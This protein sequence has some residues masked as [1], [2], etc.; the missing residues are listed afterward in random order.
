M[1][2]GNTGQFWTLGVSIPTAAITADARKQCLTAILIGVVALVVILLV[3]TA[4]VRALT[5]PLNQRKLRHV[6]SCNR[7]T[8]QQTAVIRPA[9]AASSSRIIRMKRF[10]R[11][12]M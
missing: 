3:L 1:K 4:V 7:T 12:R 2:V 8:L 9:P 11:S 10:V 5:R 6:S